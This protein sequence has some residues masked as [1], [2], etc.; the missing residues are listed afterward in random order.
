MYDLAGEVIY[1][2]RRKIL[3][4]A[5]PATSVQTLPVKK[6]VPW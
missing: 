5:F 1:V 6:H 2:E 4:N 3:K